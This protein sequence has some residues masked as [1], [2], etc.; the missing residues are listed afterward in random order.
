VSRAA[1]IKKFQLLETDF[2]QPGGELTPT[3]KLRRKFTESKYQLV[4]D[5]IYA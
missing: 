2:T 4:I 3:M 1:H 5:Q